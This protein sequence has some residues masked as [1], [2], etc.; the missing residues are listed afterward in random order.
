MVMRSADIKCKLGSGIYDG[1]ILKKI[2]LKQLSGG[3]DVLFFPTDCLDFSSQRPSAEMHCNLWS[4]GFSGLWTWPLGR[5]W[6]ETNALV[7]S[8]HSDKFLLGTKALQLLEV[9]VN[10][11]R[12]IFR[13]LYLM[14]GVVLLVKFASIWSVFSI[15]AIDQVCLCYLHC[16][17][18]IS[19]HCPQQGEAKPNAEEVERKGKES[20]TSCCI[21]GWGEKLWCSSLWNQGISQNFSGQS[22]KQMLPFQS[23][24]HICK[25]HTIPQCLTTLYLILCFPYKLPTR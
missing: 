10:L 15:T 14:Y 20:V 13:W 6:C 1:L 16:S 4:A 25:V 22:W 12:I 17:L 2:L 9:H 7:F 24:Y 21:V 11:K 18:A 19:F 3:S 8:L 5:Y 23:E